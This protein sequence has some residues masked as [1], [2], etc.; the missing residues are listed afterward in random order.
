MTSV[1]VNDSG[2]APQMT[3]EPRPMSVPNPTMAATVRGLP[4][5]PSAR[6]EQLPRLPGHRHSQNTPAPSLLETPDE[7]SARIAADPFHGGSEPNV[8]SEPEKHAEFRSQSSPVSIPVQPSRR[9]E[10]PSLAAAAKE[11]QPPFQ[12]PAPERQQADSRTGRTIPAVVRP[13][14]AVRQAAPNSQRDLPSSERAGVESR[15]AAPSIH[16]TIG[17]VEIRAISTPARPQ[18]VNGH[19]IPPLSLDAYLKKSSGG[20]SP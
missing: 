12:S 11:L 10:V 18:T 6:S 20:G 1:L 5:L 14:A 16:V 4:P 19:S 9:D 3:A 2:P 17:R 7:T 15:T 13:V 8:P